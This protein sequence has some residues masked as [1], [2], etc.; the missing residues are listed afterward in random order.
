V[1]LISNCRYEC[2]FPMD[3]G[4]DFRET[5]EV[6]PSRA[7]SSL[8]LVRFF[9]PKSHFCNCFCISFQKAGHKLSCEEVRV[10][11]DFTLMAL[12]RVWNSSWT[13]ATHKSF[14]PG[15]KQAIRTFALCTNRLNL[16]NEIV[17]RVGTFLNRSWW[18]DNRR[19][20]W[21]H[22]CQVDQVSRRNIA[23]ATIV[24]EAFQKSG[25]RSLIIWN[26]CDL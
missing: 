21:S 13:P 18:P 16:P 15:F 10:R 3:G 26:V 1:R 7:R 5:D 11:Y 2:D 22:A 25:T 20:C 19:R 24:V 9:V 6:G 23:D 8:K 4:T 14:Q 17:E 12:L